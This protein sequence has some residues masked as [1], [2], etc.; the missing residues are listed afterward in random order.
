MHDDN[1]IKKNNSLPCALPTVAGGFF[2]FSNREWKCIERAF[3]PINTLTVDDCAL[4]YIQVGLDTVQQSQL[5]LQSVVKVNLGK[6]EVWRRAL[7]SRQEAKD[8]PLL[9][10][11]ERKRRSFVQPP[12]NILLA[13]TKVDKE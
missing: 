11:E 8:L 1:C 10:A 13:D 5:K 4:A 12:P 3:T 6:G 7:R 9:L 2:F